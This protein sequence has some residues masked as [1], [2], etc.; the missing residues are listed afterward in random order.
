MGDDRRREGAVR[1][2]LL[3]AV[4]LLAAAVP[5]CGPADDGGT[6]GADGPSA[7]RPTR[8]DT[9]S[10]EP[11]PGRSIHEVLEE[12]RETWMARPEVT[13]TGIGRC[14]GDPCIVLYLLR[15]TEAVQEAV[16]DSVDGHPV[17]LEVTGRIEP[18]SG[19]ADTAGEGG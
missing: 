14:E 2:L 13:G 9:V 17:R 18:R 3:P 1:A 6:A 16:P 10:E 4:L 7:E 15:R 11:G 5:A 8:G 19:P 12:H